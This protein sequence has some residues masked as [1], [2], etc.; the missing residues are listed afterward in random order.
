MMKILG[1]LKYPELP[2]TLKAQVEQENYLSGYAISGEDSLIVW[3]LNN[4]TG[5]QQELE[6]SIFENKVL[7]RAERKNFLPAGQKIVLPS[8]GV[9]VLQYFA[10]EAET[11]VLYEIF[12]IFYIN[13]NTKITQTSQIFFTKYKNTI[14][15]L[16]NTAINEYKFPAVYASWSDDEKVN[17]WVETMYR[18][19]HQ[20]GEAGG[21]E[22]DI[23]DQS[24]IDQMKNID[25]K[26]LAI[27]PS[28]LKRLA[29]VEQLDEAQ[30]ISTFV[31]QTGLKF[32]A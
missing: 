28:C 29:S 10:L 16:V 20:T 2:S 27:L 19:R 26:F 14:E 22:D 8:I 13:A 1:S 17:Y 11:D 31:S 12:D 23:F 15:E 21:K 3:V 5:K 4:S 7:T 32:T 24:L 18:M 25:A 6:F 9:E 30:L